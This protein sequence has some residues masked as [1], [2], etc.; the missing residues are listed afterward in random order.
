MT[1][2]VDSAVVVTTDSGDTLGYVASFNPDG[3][4]TV[5]LD[6]GVTETVSR[7]QVA[8]PTLDNW[9]LNRVRR[10]FESDPLAR[11]AMT[12][13]QLTDYSWTDGYAK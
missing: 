12:G 9:P 5:D 11:P 8:T 3:T 1:Y 10:A 7:D 4:V 6:S 13:R 2:S